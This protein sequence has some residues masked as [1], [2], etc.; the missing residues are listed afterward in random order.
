MFAKLP[1][2]TSPEIDNPKLV[3]FGGAKGSSELF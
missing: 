2:I 1:N 3:V